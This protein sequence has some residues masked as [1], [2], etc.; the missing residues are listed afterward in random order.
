MGTTTALSLFARSKAGADFTESNESNPTLPTAFTGGE[1]LSAT[2]LTVDTTPATVTSSINHGSCQRHSSEDCPVDRRT[3]SG[4]ALHWVAPS[5]DRGSVSTY[6]IT[7]TNLDHPSKGGQTA[8]AAT[9]S[10]PVALPSGWD[11]Y[12]SWSGSLLTRARW[13]LDGEAD[14]FGRP[15]SRPWN[16]IDNL[17][18]GDRY[19]FSVTAHRP[20]K[21]DAVSALTSPVKVPADVPD[22]VD[23]VE[24]TPGDGA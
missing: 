11:Q 13:V 18:G 14:L 24:V 9:W 5:V 10:H 19:A 22:K 17:Q 7:A 15:Y 23:R 20:G 21:P 16:G 6:T 3:R 1:T 8:E 2:G 4:A 12:G